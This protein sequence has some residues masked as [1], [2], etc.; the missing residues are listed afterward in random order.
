MYLTAWHRSWREVE[1]RWEVNVIADCRARGGEPAC[2]VRGT[3]EGSLAAA[4]SSSTSVAQRATISSRPDEGE[5]GRM[6]RLYVTPGQRRHR[7]V[8]ISLITWA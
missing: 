7:R 6:N 2:Q 8:V 1:Y 3:T 4:R 5:T